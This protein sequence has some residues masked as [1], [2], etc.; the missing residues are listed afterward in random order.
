MICDGFWNEYPG[1]KN[2]DKTALGDTQDLGDIYFA[3][4][5]ACYRAHRN[6]RGG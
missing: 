3:S 6:F 1:L 2:W 4:E 5:Y